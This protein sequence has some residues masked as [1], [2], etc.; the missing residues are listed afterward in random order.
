MYLESLYKFLIKS[1]AL[2]YRS[3][4]DRYF[5]KLLSNGKWS[6][7]LL[8]KAITLLG[9]VLKLALLP[10]SFVEFL[11]LPVGWIKKLVKWQMKGCAYFWFLVT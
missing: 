4:T 10:K 2:L 9:T 7:K 11:S 6:D 8:V 1:S 3:Y 5:L